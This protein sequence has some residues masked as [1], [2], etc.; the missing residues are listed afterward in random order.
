MKSLVVYVFVM[1]VL[2]YLAMWFDKYQ[3]KK[4]GFRIPESRLFLLAVMFGA[5]GIYL[6]MQAPIYHKAAKPKFKI[7][8]PILIIVNL[9]SLYLI[10]RY[11]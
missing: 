2:A 3:A 10:Y 1:N 11:Q 7:G 6:G 4:K 5:L 9:I 8:V